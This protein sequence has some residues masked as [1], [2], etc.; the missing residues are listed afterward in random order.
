MDLSSHTT[1]NKT[2]STTRPK[3]TNNRDVISTDSRARLDQFGHSARLILDFI[4]NLSCNQILSESVHDE[5]ACQETYSMPIY[6]RQRRGPTTTEGTR[7]LQ[8]RRSRQANTSA[9][10]FSVLVTMQL[11]TTHPLEHAQS[12]DC[13]LF[14]ASTLAAHTPESPR[15]SAPRSGERGYHAN[16]F[17]SQKPVSH[18]YRPLALTEVNMRGCPVR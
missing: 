9:P 4:L 11:R 12:I 6:R 8:T 10:F 5:D 15:D 2:F 16:V 7:P 18:R 14:H 17:S 3:L 1:C 13:A